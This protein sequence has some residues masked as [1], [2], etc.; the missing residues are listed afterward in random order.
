MNRTLWLGIYPALG[1]AQLDFIFETIE[2][3]LTD[4]KIN[5]TIDL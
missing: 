4:R 1:E 2:C 3:F 5:I